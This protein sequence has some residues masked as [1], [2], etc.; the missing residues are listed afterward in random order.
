[1]N[2]ICGSDIKRDI[3][4]ELKCD[5]DVN[6]MDIAVSVTDGVATLTGYVRDFS[7]KYAA[8]DAAKRVRG[9]D[10]GRKRH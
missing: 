6:E 3:E 1:M 10:R 8:E 2:G 9:S 4:V 5:A 7:D